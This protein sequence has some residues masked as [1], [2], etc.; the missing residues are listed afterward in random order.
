MAATALWRWVLLGLSSHPFAAPL[1]LLLLVAQPFLR[2]LAPMPSSR[3]ALETALDWAFP[4]GLLGA[5]LS[6][7]LLSRGTP[8]LSR[9]DQET[10]FRGEL[11]ALLASAIYLQLPILL[12]ALLAG[13]AV[14]ELGRALPAILTA[15][16]HLAGIAIL[17]LVPA[18]S[19]AL[20]ASLFLSAAWFLPALC[21]ADES[22]ARVSLL[23]DAG[24]ALRAAAHGVPTTLA[25][26]VALILSAHLLR[27]GPTRSASG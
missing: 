5:A 21:S 7:I 22:L 19:T 24:A 11:G 27:T 1:W 16:L 3:S 15:D 25:A 10:R 2:S 6:L 9:L 13:A 8:F 23:L 12:G 4:A 17:L 20:R 14:G 26:A 18:L